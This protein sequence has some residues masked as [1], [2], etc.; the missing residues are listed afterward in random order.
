MPGRQ[1]QGADPKQL[2]PGAGQ[3]RRQHDKRPKA[4]RMQAS[5][6]RAMTPPASI[7]KPAAPKDAT[8]QTLTLTEEG[9]K[10]LREARLPGAH[11]AVRT[12]CKEKL[13]GQRLAVQADKR[14]FTSY[15]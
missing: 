11:G 1:A 7:K 8:G 9:R 5:S 15:R 2:N 14:I 10:P 4:D 13:P 12:D 3:R 6:T